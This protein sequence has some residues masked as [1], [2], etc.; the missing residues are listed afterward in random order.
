MAKE[1]KLTNQTDI[2]KWENVSSED[3]LREKAELEDS[4]GSGAFFNIKKP[5]KYVIR[6]IPALAG[7]RWKRVTY[8]HYIDAPGVGRVSFICPKMEVKQSCP[9]CKMEQKYAASDKEIDQ[10]RAFKFKPK[11]RCLS[12][13][14]DRAHP[15]DGPKVFAFGVMVE[16]QLIELLSDEDVG[17]NFLHPVKGYDVGVLRTGVGMN[18]TEYKVY[19]A[20]KG[21]VLTLHDDVVIV[22]EWLTNQHNLERF[23]KVYSDNDIQKLLRGEKP[24]GDERDE[25]APPARRI[26]DEI[27]EKFDEDEDS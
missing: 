13:V 8:M 21:K 27:E 24:G 20:N 16:K 9:A 22:N 23:V 17:G 11:R 5:G 2:V 6:F 14:I 4:R 19:P 3:V 7:R 25:E 10:K 15:E 18:D 1:P 26:D 12:N